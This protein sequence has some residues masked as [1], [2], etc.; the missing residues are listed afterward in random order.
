MKL[1]AA[2]LVFVAAAAAQSTNVGVYLGWVGTYPGN[3]LEV[4]AN[5]AKTSGI[6]TIRVPLV[7]SVD[8]DFDIGRQCESHLTL[9]EIAALRQYRDVFRDPALK[10]I[11]LTT[12]GDSRSY[13]PCQPRDPRSDQHPHKLYLDKNYYYSASRD[14]MRAE[15][16]DL[17]YHLY[18]TYHGSG[19][20]FGISNWEGDNELYC[21]AAL[22]FV[23]RPAFR[24]MCESERT[25]G[26]V[27]VAYREYLTLRHQGIEDGRSRAAQHGLKDV[28]VVDVVE[29]SA[30]HSLNGNP[31]LLQDVIPN[32]PAPGLVSYSA[33]ESLGDS[34]AKDLAE[35]KNRFHEKLIIGEFGFDRGLD[36]SAPAKLEATLKTIRENQIPCA[37]FWQMFDQPPLE[38]L[39][40]KGLYGL[41]D[42][43]LAITDLGQRILHR[44][45]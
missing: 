17:T 42:R 4:G 28:T 26:D 38:G 29:F 21:D 15:Y 25:T 2:A 16:S 24:S 10:T 9:R 19:K 20:L 13:N 7:A 45:Q 6:D 12:W 32:V 22:Y 27:I 5:L 18:E 3:R 23:T 40:D 34:L 44:H 37:I 35:L 8:I 11:F 39:G 1:F 31:G 33:W 41:Y 14:R 36:P 30:F 43:N